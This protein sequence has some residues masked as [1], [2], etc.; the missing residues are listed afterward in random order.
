M[1]C[2]AN[3][4]QL[5]AALSA[6]VLGLLVYLFSRSAESIYLFTAFSVFPTQQYDLFGVIGYWLPSFLHTYAFILLTVISIGNGPRIIITCSLFWVAIG[7][8]FEL[9]QH[10]TV[11]TLLV[12]YFPEWFSGIPLLENS[13]N[14]FQYGTFDPLDLLATLTG[15]LAAWATYKL[16]RQKDSSH[17]ASK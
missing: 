17:A 4:F 3:I 9:G 5:A 7:C 15:A 16:T 6:L 1:P 13:A 11:S 14:Y 2:K 12:K 8:L 10:P